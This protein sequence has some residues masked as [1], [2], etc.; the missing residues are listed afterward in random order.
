MPST[1]SVNQLQR[2]CVIHNSTIQGLT[3][4]PLAKVKSRTVLELATILRAC[5][6]YPE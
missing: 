4:A 2:Q 5:E 3:P 1:S 6:Q